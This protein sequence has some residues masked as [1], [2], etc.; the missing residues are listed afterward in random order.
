MTT[1]IW[2]RQDLR[3]ADNPALAAAAASG[4]AVIPLYLFAPE[5]EGAW[6]PGGASRWWLHQ[7]LASLRESLREAGSDLCIRRG[8]DS[9]GIL[10]DLIAESGATR[11]CF[12][13]RYEPAAVARD[14]ALKTAL[15]ARGIAVETH[16]SA[17]LFEPWTVSTKSG[18]PFQVFTP[19][20]RHCRALEAPP[21]PIRAPERLHPPPSGPMGEAL[22]SLELLPALD[23][24]KG[25]AAAFTPG[26][27]SALSHLEHFVE[28]GFDDYATERDHP[29]VAGT[30]RLSPHLH[31]G[32]IGPRQV[33]DAVKRHAG[34][35]G[36]HSTWRDSQFLTELGWREFAHHLLFHFPHTPEQPLRESFARFPWKSEPDALAAWRR[37]RTGYPIVDAGMRELWSSGWM[38]NRVRMIVGSFLVKDLLIPWQEGARWFWDTLVDA[39]LANNTLGWQWVSG[40][41]ADAAPFF[42]IFNPVSQGE[43]FD[44]AGEYVRR[45]VP[46][47]AALPDEW[48]HRPWTAPPEILESA[49]ITLG[50]TYPLPRVDHDAARKDALAA[51]ARIKG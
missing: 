13:R 15:E 36:R 47:I 5:E 25:L 41:G 14:R 34:R 42:R 33:Y 24:P 31:F 7:S 20:W 32:E 21:E 1:L 40:C 22:E 46:E 6:G 45:W 29:G 39:D 8:P 43:R 3:L 4:E 27:R 44:G 48:L 49:G 23:W 19:F 38:H 16:N 51:F 37:G 30:S 28:A 10:L 18:H 12:N 50:T 35:R 11:V 17:L 9:L 26:E 2:F